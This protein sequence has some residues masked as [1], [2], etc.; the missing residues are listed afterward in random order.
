MAVLMITSLSDMGNYQEMKDSLLE[1]VKYFK[2][3]H[4]QL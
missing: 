4:V 3:A 1:S 2:P